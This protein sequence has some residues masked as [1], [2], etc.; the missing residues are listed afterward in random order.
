VE[1]VEQLFGELCLSLD[2]ADTGA[3]DQRFLM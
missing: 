3:G 1:T 2:P